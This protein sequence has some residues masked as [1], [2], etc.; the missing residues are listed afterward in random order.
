MSSRFG[1]NG[2]DLRRGIRFFSKFGICD[3]SNFST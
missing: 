2:G 1:S 3:L